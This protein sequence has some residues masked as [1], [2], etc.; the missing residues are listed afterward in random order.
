[1]LYKCNDGSYAT[2]VTSDSTNIQNLRQ[3][4]EIDIIRLK[5]FEEGAVVTIP[6]KYIRYSLPKYHIYIRFIVLIGY[7]ILLALTFNIRDIF[8]RDIFYSFLAAIIAIYAVITFYLMRR[9]NNLL[10]TKGLC[11]NI[12][13]WKKISNIKIIKKQRFGFSNLNIISLTLN[14]NNYIIALS[15][16]ELTRLKELGVLLL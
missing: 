8:Y 13:E 14:S 10:N 1:M 2:I 15:D 6:K 3:R 16:K 5:A 11:I 9:S 4:K 7:L 12:D